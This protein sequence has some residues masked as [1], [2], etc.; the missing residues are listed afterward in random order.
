M[1]AGLG[2]SLSQLALVLREQGGYARAIALNEECLALH[3]E[4]G[5]REVTDI[6]AVGCIYSIAGLPRGGAIRM[7]L[8]QPEDHA[9]VRPAIDR[10]VAA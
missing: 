10:P 9:V 5:D 2:A 1:R 6:V 7:L 4:L 8:R 3:R